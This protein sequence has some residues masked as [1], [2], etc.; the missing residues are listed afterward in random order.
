MNNDIRL[1]LEIKPNLFVDIV[2]LIILLAA[3]CNILMTHEI[4]YYF[5]SIA[6]ISLPFMAGM[7]V[8][9]YLANKYNLYW[10]KNISVVI[11]FVIGLTLFLVINI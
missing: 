11:S 2:T 3:L 5:L 1:S 4:T 8:G 6:V 9:D 10:I 7:I